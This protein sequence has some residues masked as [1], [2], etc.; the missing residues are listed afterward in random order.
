MGWGALQSRGRQES[1]PGGRW[2]FVGTLKSKG[3]T[4]T[5]SEVGREWQPAAPSRLS[6]SP[7][8]PQPCSCPGP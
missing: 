2:H 3:M 4:Q 8:T 1:I 7:C 5:A 6:L